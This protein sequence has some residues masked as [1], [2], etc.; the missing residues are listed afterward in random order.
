M[1][2]PVICTL[3]DFDNTVTGWYRQ[4]FTH[5]EPLCEHYGGEVATLAQLNQS[6]ANGFDACRC[7]WIADGIAVYVVMS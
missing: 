5:A 4:N 2:L 6:L 7:G 1:A 3:Q